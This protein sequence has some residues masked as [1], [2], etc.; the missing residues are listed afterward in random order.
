M[1]V[2]GSVGVTYLLTLFKLNI[3]IVGPSLLPGAVLVPRGPFC[4]LNP[5][6]KWRHHEA[7]TGRFF[8]SERGACVR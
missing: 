8:R 7:V 4:S 2:D 1:Q 5:S 6:L 3:L